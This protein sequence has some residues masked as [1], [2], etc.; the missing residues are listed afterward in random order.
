M[1]Y[2]LS[3]IMA[4]NGV[5]L[6]D[7]ICIAQQG[8]ACAACPTGG[9]CESMTGFID[10]INN[11]DKRLIMYNGHSS[12]LG[13]TFNNL[14]TNTIV[15]NDI[16]NTEPTVVLPMACYTTYYEDPGTASLADQLLF[17]A[18]G[19]SVA[20]SGAATLSSLGDNGTFTESILD[21]MCDGTTT[22]A[23]AVFETKNEKP[24]PYRPG[25]KLGPYRERLLLL[26]LSV[27]K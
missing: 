19:G 27:R 14:L 6:N 1:N 11:N 5:S 3:D 23:E 16:T 15:E 2:Y 12:I 20:V 21:K 10:D 13:W 26:L 4:D 7:A 25:D 22:L 8:A 9:P 17:K 18:T 24:R